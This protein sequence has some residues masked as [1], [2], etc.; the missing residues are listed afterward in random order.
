MTEPTPR[1]MPPTSD[2]NRAAA[3]RGAAV[4]GVLV[5]ARIMSGLVT[6]AV[7]VAAV[8]GAALL[9]LPTLGGDVRSALVEP[10]AVDTTRVCAGPILR[11]GADDGTDATRANSIGEADLRFAA[12]GGSPV[13]GS[14]DSTD[15]T[16]G[17]TPYRI[18]L[19]PISDEQLTLA[20]SQSQSIAS[21]GLIGFAAVECSTA[22]SDSWIVAGSTETGRTTLLTLSN[23]APVQSIVTLE[24]Y[25]ED[26]RVS[27]TGLEGIVVPVGGQRIVS[28]AGWAP[29]AES[30]VVR[31]TSSGGAIVAHLQQSVTRVLT[32]GGA[33]IV[34][35][36]MAPALS[37][38]IPG[39]IVDS[40]SAVED[41]GLGGDFHDLASIVRLLAP[42]DAD[43]QAVLTVRPTPGTVTPVVDNGEEGEGRAAET[44][45][46]PIELKAGVVTDLPFDQL[47]DG[48]YTITVDSNVPIVAAAR[49]ST[50]SSG[51]GVRLDS[52]EGPNAGASGAIDFAWFTTAPPLV[53]TALV[54]VAPGPGAMLHLVNTT[55]NPA[56]VMVEAS[57]GASPVEE[58]PAGGSLAVPVTA[59]GSYTLSGFD[60]LYISVSYAG[61]GGL[62]GFPVTGPLPLA[63]AVRVYH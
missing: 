11:L 29:D 60:A 23:P 37:A 57:T 7:M 61:E 41:I 6:V 28:I 32:P 19:P 24:L 31:V 12:S 53:N 63:A 33:D 30:I 51:E 15:G 22:S 16:T 39:F 9:P 43:A 55:A 36:G 8:G 14:L 44:I 58:V 5:G 50:V 21:G 25:T 52:E 10:E 26:G 49:S 2:E 59:G 38:V 46:V 35:R 4:R 17:V 3:A 56:R 1:T 20:A 13:R 18:D 40:H 48:S 47:L 27:A 62:A 45:V 42:G 34:A 54:S